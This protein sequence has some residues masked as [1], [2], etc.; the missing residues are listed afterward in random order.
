MLTIF[1][2]LMVAV[3]MTLIGLRRLSALA[4]LILV[5]TL[6]GLLA[7]FGS[8]LGPMMLTGIKDLAPT[9]VMLVFAILYFGVMIDAGLFAPLVDLIVKGVRG[10]PVRTMIGTVVLALIVGLDGDGST[11]YMITIVAMLPLFRSLKLDVRMLACLAIMASGVSNMLPW[12]GPTARAASALHLDPAALFVSMLP[13]VLCTTGWVFFVA[14]LFGRRERSRLSRDADGVVVAPAEIDEPM[15][16]EGGK[17]A[18]RPRL[19]WFNLVLTLALLAGLVLGVLPLAVLF[20]LAFAVA[21]VVN[22]PKLED[23]RERLYAHAGNA[24]AVGGLVFA[25]GIFTGILNG[26]GMVQAMAGSVIEVI[27]AG[28]GPYM[29][30]ITA[31]LS[32]PF[33]FL[34]SN[35]A[36]Y[37]GMLPVL[38]QTGAAYGVTPEQMARASLVGQ[39]VH[40][41]S[42]LVPSTYLLVSMVGI[43]L[44]EHQRFTLRWALGAAAVMLLAA[45][46]IGAFPL[47]AT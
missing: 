9:G 32:V 47:S 37:F 19:I 18:K 34:I 10:D 23:Q 12:G 24:L 25:A 3:F 5:P 1:G 14:W 39:Q 8:Q 30:P 6:V 28:A 13:A 20:M 35:D 29:A 45:L 41:L 21:M 4:A 26:T 46:L 16:P 44:G 11:T 22:Y 40:L 17:S 38:A 27:P 2:F 7:G 36:F 33:T 15:L 42:P 43:E 31:V